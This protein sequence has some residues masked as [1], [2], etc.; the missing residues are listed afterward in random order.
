MEDKKNGFWES[1]VKFS[2]F[3]GSVSNILT[4]AAAFIVALNGYYI[5]SLVWRITIQVVSFCLSVLLITGI[6]VRV[7]KQPIHFHG[8]GAMLPDER[9]IWETHIRKHIKECPCCKAPIENVDF[10]YGQHYIYLP[11]MHDG[12]IS[13]TS[14]VQAFP[15]FCRRCANA[16]VF[17]A[18]M[19]KPIRQNGK[20]GKDETSVTKS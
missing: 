7:V 8:S 6:I 15:A 17:N 9:K 3:A 11:L 19:L 18:S 5:E 2:E 14:Y 12:S 1:T 10:S 4:L 20:L 13:Q 16:I